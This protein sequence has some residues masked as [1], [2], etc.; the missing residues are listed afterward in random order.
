MINI[1]VTKWRN[2]QSRY[3]WKSSNSSFFFKE[4]YLLSIEKYTYFCLSEYKKDKKFDQTHI[5]RS[6]LLMAY[7]N[8]IQGWLGTGFVN[9]GWYD[10]GFQKKIISLS[11]SE[12]V[13]NGLTEWYF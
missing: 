1:S 3:G 8:S 9:L 2:I 4:N 10:L 12:F 13:I 6:F 7:L 5:Y 11:Y